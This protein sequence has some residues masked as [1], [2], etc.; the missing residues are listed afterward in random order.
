[1]WKILK[2]EWL[3]IR[4]YWAFWLVVLM[5]SLSYPGV[6]YMFLHEYRTIVA[7]EKATGKMVKLLLGNPFAFPEV[8]HTAAFFSSFFVFIPALV[9]IMLITNEYMYKTHRQNII[10][11]WSRNQFLLG[12]FLSVTIITVLVSIIFFTVSYSLGEMATDKPVANKWAEFRYV[13]LF[14]LQTFSQL[15]L[16]FLVGFFVRKAFIALGIFMFYFLAVENI[17]VTYLKFQKHDEGRF[18]PFE[19]SDRMIP[20]PKFVEKFDEK[21]YQASIAAIEPH[22][23]YTLI[24]TAAVWAVCYIVNRKRDL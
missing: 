18:L 24:L 8:F 13:P 9:V 2:T 17:A 3:K 16:A 14:A 23:I 20:V 19:I 7:K 22:I 4:S 11:G 6:N 12:K 1:M 15:S 5:T 10:D 21:A